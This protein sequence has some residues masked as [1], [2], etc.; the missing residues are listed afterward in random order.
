MF[1]ARLVP[2]VSFDMVSYGAGLTKMSGPRFA[3]AT[4]VGM[5]PLTFVYASFGELLFANSALTWVG[6]GVFVALLF[7]L[8]RWIERHDLLGM[9]H[10]FAHD[11]E[12]DS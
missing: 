11:E 1:L 7:L 12:E 2:A 9:R 10:L 5:V 3:L 8:P 4:F 6:G